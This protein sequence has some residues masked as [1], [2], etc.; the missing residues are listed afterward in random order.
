MKAHALIVWIHGSRRKL[1]VDN[2]KEGV[3]LAMDLM[4]FE[5]GMPEKIILT[6]DSGDVIDDTS[7]QLILDQKAI[8]AAGHHFE[9]AHRRG[10]G[11]L[12]SDET[13]AKSIKAWQEFV[14]SV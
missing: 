9:N 11:V 7:D 6:V 4:W 12:C 5:T 2:P 1:F 14:E 8:I 3:K 10:G 13:Q